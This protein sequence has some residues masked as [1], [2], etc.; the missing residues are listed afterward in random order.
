[1][2]KRRIALVTG[3]AGGIGRAVGAALSD[4]GMR[5]V[6]ADADA[7]RL[8][9]AERAGFET[10]TVDITVPDAVDATVAAIADRHGRLDVLVNATG[11]SPKRGG[12]RLEAWDIDAADWQRVIDCNLS[13]VFYCSVAAARRMRDRGSGA[14]VNISSVVSRVW[15]GS[16]SAAYIASKAGV[17]GLT[18]ALAMEFAPHGI[19]VNAVAPGRVRTPMTEAA[20]PEVWRRTVEAIPLRRAADPKEIAAAVLFLATEQASYLTGSILDVSG[21]RGVV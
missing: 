8:G 3:G 11:I 5:V 20:S 16:S 14:I 17:D 6:L 2:G 21:G 19:R 1:M 12:D 10:A 13:G 15:T 4:Q 18:R 9:K 7:A